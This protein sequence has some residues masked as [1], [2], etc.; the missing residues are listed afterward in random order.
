[1]NL[2]VI[3][4]RLKTSVAFP[5]RHFW[6]ETAM[7]PGWN[8]VTQSIYERAYEKAIDLLENGK[9]EDPLRIIFANNF[10]MF[11]KKLL[12]KQKNFWPKKK[13]N[14]IYQYHFK[15]INR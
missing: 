12:R 7:T 10:A 6:T 15:N 2:S 11:W 4:I 1:M 5:L 8:V 9:I 3:P 13:N 14:I